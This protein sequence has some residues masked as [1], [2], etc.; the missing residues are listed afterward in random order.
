MVSGPAAIGSSVPVINYK[1]DPGE[2]AVRLSAPEN[3]SA[4]L[5]INQELRNQ[6]RLRQEAL[7]KGEDIVYSN[8]SFHVS[9]GKNGP[10]FNSGL[11]TV[12]SKAPPQ[13]ESAIYSKP[14]QTGGNQATEAA[15]AN[16]QANNKIT[17]NS[18]E[19]SKPPEKQ[20]QQQKQ[21]IDNEDARLERNLTEARLVK[22]QALDQGNPLQFQNAKQ[23][24]NQIEQDKEDITKAKRKNEQEQVQA[25]MMSSRQA[26]GNSQNQAASPTQGML[27]VMFGLGNGSIQINPAALTPAA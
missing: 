24:E 9:V 12:V 4:Y 19:Q 27:D 13:K 10:V 25:R 7:A 15:A 20:L 18:P 6:N 8:V 1:P 21:K 22:E 5:V 16:N 11:T 26:T 14:A 17:A 23:K 2:P 3:R